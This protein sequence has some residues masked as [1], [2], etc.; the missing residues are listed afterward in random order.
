MIIPAIAILASIQTIAYIIDMTAI[1]MG[2]QGIWTHHITFAILDLL[3]VYLLSRL[4]IPYLTKVLQFILLMS[5]FSHVIGGFCYLM[6]YENGLLKY[7]KLKAVYFY[8][9]I[10]AFITYGMGGGLRKL[11]RSWSRNNHSIGYNRGYRTANVNIDQN[12]ARD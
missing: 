9:E 6:D 3:T 10:M 11:L 7:D 1:E 12:M 4:Y 2:I 5:A 8:A